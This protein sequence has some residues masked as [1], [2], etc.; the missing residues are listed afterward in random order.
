MAYTNPYNTNNKADR[1]ETLI[2]ELN[3]LS[4]KRYSYVYT[5]KHYLYYHIANQRFMFRFAERIDDL[6]KIVEILI[7]YRMIEYESEDF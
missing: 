6:I 1:L 2:A 3:Q 5:D 7:R 4:C